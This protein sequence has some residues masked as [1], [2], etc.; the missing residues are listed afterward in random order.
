MDNAKDAKAQVAL[1]TDSWASNK[2]EEIMCL[3]DSAP[4]TKD[5][6]ER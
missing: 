6:H 1:V 3:L 4:E 2:I 5:H